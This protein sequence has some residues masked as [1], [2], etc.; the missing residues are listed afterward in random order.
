[1]TL[2]RVE[3]GKAEQGK[4]LIRAELAFNNPFPF[5]VTVRESSLMLR[6]GRNELGK[7]ALKT[8]VSIPAGSRKPVNVFMKAPEG[9]LAKALEGAPANAQKVWLSG[10]VMIAPVAGV[11][12]MPLI[13]KA[14]DSVVVK[15]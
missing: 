7:V 5:P 4:E 6:T 9:T 1:M 12:A 13:V 2:K 8:A 3:R 15:K 14:N 10:D 11:L